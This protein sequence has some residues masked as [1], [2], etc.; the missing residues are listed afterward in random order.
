[1]S[2]VKPLSNLNEMSAGIQKLWIW[3]NR[4]NYFKSCDYLQKIDFCIRDLNEEIDVL[5]SPSMKEVIY[6]I[7]LIDW[8]REAV[9]EIHKL[10]KDGLIDKFTYLRDDE[11]RE[12]NSYF[13]AIRSF[14]V[15]HP[16]S[17]NR[18]QSYGFDGNKI[19]VDIKSKTST[20]T[21]IITHSADWYHLDLKGLT[22]NTK[23]V[24]ADFVLYI[25]SKQKDNMQF[26]KYVGAN[27]NDLYYVAELQIDKLYA[28]DRYLG[29]LRKKDWIW[30]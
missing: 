11:M 29:K 16:L 26:Y 2:E 24:H 22:P 17:T 20:L 23:D 18:H 27:F 4:E 7:V 15:A 19:C 10:L 25:Y 30:K 12:A 1:M 9:D 5:K 13:K 8:I 3:Q 21:Q 14:A 28:L 6:T